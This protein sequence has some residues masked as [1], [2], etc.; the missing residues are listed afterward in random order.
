M[1]SYGH[2]GPGTDDNKIGSDLLYY[3]KNSYYGYAQ[4]EKIE[5]DA[6]TI[7][8]SPARKQL[9]RFIFL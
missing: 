7:H 2:F 3:K 5:L 6:G 1:I 4:R 8:K 9:K